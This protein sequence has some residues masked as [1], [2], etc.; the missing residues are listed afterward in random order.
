MILMIGVVK[1]SGLAT[2]LKTVLEIVS[3]FDSHRHCPRELPFFKTDTANKQNA[4]DCYISIK[5]IN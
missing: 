4:Y 3:E 1:R 2:V 5:Y